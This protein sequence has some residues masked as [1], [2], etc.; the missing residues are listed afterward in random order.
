MKQLR[1]TLTV[2]AVSVLTALITT[3]PAAASPAVGAGA[4]SV[5]ARSTFLAYENA[6][7]DGRSKSYSTC[8]KNVISG[9]RG[10]YKWIAAGQ[11]AS[12]YNNSTTSGAAHTRFD[13][14]NS[15]SSS[16]GFGWKSMFLHC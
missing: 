16:S 1:A 5:N 8:G 3:F 7:F 10:S 9:Y 14:A 15:A 12:M 13:S 11:S 2:G 4:S 6:N